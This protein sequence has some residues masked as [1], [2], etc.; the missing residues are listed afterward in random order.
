V[1]SGGWH[2]CKWR[3]GR[4]HRSHGFWGGLKDMMQEKNEERYVMIEVRPE[5]LR[6]KQ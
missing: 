6:G 5:A 2:E 3:S 1:T 4:S